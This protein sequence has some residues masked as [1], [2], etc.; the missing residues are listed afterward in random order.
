M[1]AGEKS[2]R[3]E[4]MK[5]HLYR[6]TF[7]MPVQRR[8]LLQRFNFRT[9]FPLRLISRASMTLVEGPDLLQPRIVLAEINERSSRTMGS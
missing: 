3:V 4:N 5:A 2:E 9:G 6:F 8:S 1:P 7:Y